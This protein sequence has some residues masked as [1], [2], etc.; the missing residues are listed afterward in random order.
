MA[1]TTA[2]TRLRASF[3]ALCLLMAGVGWVGQP[4]TTGA[5][6]RVG[7]TYA[8][9]GQAA[10]IDHPGCP[11]PDSEPTSSPLG[12]AVTAAATAAPNAH[13]TVSATIGYVTFGPRLQRIDPG[14][15]GRV[16]S[17]RLDVV[18]AA[19]THDPQLRVDVDGAR[20]L[21]CPSRALAPGH[22]ARVVLRVWVPAVAGASWIRVAAAVRV[23]TQPGAATSL[24]RTSYRVRVAAA[25]P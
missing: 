24:F 14:E 4:D 21:S 18:A 1:D 11:L 9:I 23:R 19:G 20:L 10:G 15:A 16:V 17:L 5:E 7:G 2:R 12:T 22:V 3:S 13:G 6:H 25:A 8:G